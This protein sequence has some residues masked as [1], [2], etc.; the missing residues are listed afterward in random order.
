MNDRLEFKKEGKINT[1]DQPCGSVDSNGRLCEI[2]N[3]TASVSSGLRNERLRYLNGT[4]KILRSNVPNFDNRKKSR[5]SFKSLEVSRRSKSVDRFKTERPK[6]HRSNESYNDRGKSKTS[7][8]SK[9][10]DENLNES[11]CERRRPLIKY[12]AKPFYLHE[13][14]YNDHT[15]IHSIFCEYSCEQS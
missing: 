2:I 15:R 6:N 9:S 4:R 10:H 12:D 1:S 11:K 5:K 14:H 7:H 8:R 13:K 3:N